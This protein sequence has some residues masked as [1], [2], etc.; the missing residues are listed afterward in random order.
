MPYRFTFVPLLIALWLALG[1]GGCRE[2]SGGP[3]FSATPPPKSPPP[4]STT[5]SV[6]P[7][8]AR[9]AAGATITFTASIN[10]SNPQAGSVTWS[11]NPASGGTITSSGVYTASGNA[12]SYIVTATW[13]PFNPAG[14]AAISSSVTVVVLPAPQLVFQLNP[15]IIQ[16]Y[17]ANQGAGAIQNGAVAGQLFPSVTST[18]PSGNIQSRSGLNIPVACTASGTIC[19]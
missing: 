6:S 13:A 10:A 16:A 18:D 14:G 15:N 5:I 19:P 3:S 7:P 8:S 2:V 4:N 17:G 12:G 9:V 11:I 1:L